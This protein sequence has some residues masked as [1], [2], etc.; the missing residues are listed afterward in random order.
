MRT[1]PDGRASEDE[2]VTLVVMTR[3]R[4]ASLLANLPRLRAATVVVDNASRDGTAAA[5][6]AAFPAVE[7]VRLRRN[8]GAAARTIGAACASTP[9]VAFADD[10]SWWETGALTAA[11]QVLDEHPGVAGVCA[12]IALAPDGRTDGICELLRDSPLDRDGLPGP[13]VLGFV[14]CA[15]VLRRS[16]LLAV[17]GFDRV[18]RFP[19]EEDRVAWDLAAAGRALVYRDDVVAWHAPGSVDRSGDRRSVAVARSAVLTAVLRLPWRRVRERVVGVARDGTTRR[20]LL[21]VL[22]RL[23][24]ALLQRRPLPPQVLVDLDRLR[25]A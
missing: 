15:T 19:G 10:D 12:R 11:A 17:G 5:V 18:V 4:R 9:Y 25:A 13:R 14:A 20:A 16:D 1:C 6:A 3:D 22:A 24:A 21:G 7:V 2:R 23:P 8:L